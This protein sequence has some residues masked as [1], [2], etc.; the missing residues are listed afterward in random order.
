MGKALLEAAR[1]RMWD[2]TP[3]SHGPGSETVRLGKRHIR[4][5]D[6][7]AIHLQ[8]IRDRNE[9][10]LAVG[11]MAFVCI[12]TLFAYLV[13]DAGW[14][15]RFL[16]GMG[17]LMFLGIAG[18]GEITGLK[19]QKLYEMIITLKDG[20]RVVFTSSDRADIEVLALRLTTAGVRA[21]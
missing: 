5:C 2:I 21:F 13:F 10:G 15:T 19:T 9:D 12:A 1:P 3:G 6:I 7:D 4:L 16:L 18:I 20:E 14:R 8:E 17:F 11:A